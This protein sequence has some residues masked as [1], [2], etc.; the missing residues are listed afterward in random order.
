[1][2]SIQNF[3]RFLSLG[4]NFNLASGVF[5]DSIGGS[6][7][8]W[9]ISSVGYGLF[10]GAT[11]TGIL[12]LNNNNISDIQGLSGY[13]DYP[14][15]IGS[16]VIISGG[17][18]VETIFQA[19]S[20]WAY[21]TDGLFFA[22]GKDIFWSTGS[23]WSDTQDISLGRSGSNELTIGDCNGGYGNFVLGNLTANGIVQFFG[24]TYAYGT[25]I[26]ENELDI[27]S[28]SIAMNGNTIYMDNGEIDN[29]GTIN[30]S[31]LNISSGGNLSTPV[32]TLL[33]GGSI[34]SDGTN[35]SL[36]G[37]NAATVNLATGA[38]HFANIIKSGDTIQSN[39]ASVAIFA[40]NT[41]GLSQLGVGQDSTHA[42]GFV[43]NYNSNP[44]SASAE[45]YTYGYSNPITID[46]AQVKI[47]TISGFGV[48]IGGPVALNSNALDMDGGTI[49]LST[50]SSIQ[51]IT[52]AGELYITATSYN[53]AGSSVGIVL[54]GNKLS[55]DNNSYMLPDLSGNVTFTGTSFII[56]GLFFPQQAITTSAPSYIKGAIYFDT[57]LNKLRIGGA[58]GW[59]TITSA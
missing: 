55:F 43:W 16:D 41:T 7:S 44:S 3:S 45:M 42:C 23:S 21:G 24:N 54:H 39:V 1:M 8:N 30:A 13:A 56:D 32:V 58:I 57:T 6:G 35:L 34:S 51:D 33:N 46:A 22:N 25:L 36:G 10:S 12:T 11:I 38:A 2:P 59:E 28:G 17:L 53:F 37:T 48:V 26:I 47:Q 29:A 49:N 27:A 19:S 31:Y 9:S 50:Y 15:S 52:N 18:T 20:L 40:G 5:T 14:I 4:Q